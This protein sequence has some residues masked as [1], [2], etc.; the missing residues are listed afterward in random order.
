MFDKAERMLSQGLTHVDATNLK[1]QKVRFDMLDGSWP[2]AHSDLTYRSLR[3]S[4]SMCGS[5]TPKHA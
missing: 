5:S 1:L 2:L 3:Q 4:L